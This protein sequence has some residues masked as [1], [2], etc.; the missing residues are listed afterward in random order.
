MDQSR[1]NLATFQK[2]VRNLIATVFS[3]HKNRFMLDTLVRKVM[4]VSPCKIEDPQPYWF[5]VD[6]FQTYRPSEILQP[7]E[8][9]SLKDPQSELYL[10]GV[11]ALCYSRKNEYA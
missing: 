11:K 1:P 7:F 10:V 2:S 6:L 9:F 8:H 4:Q 3:N 5:F